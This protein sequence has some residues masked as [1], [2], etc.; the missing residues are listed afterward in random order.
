MKRLMFRWP[1]MAEAGEGGGGGETSAATATAAQDAKPAEEPAAEAALTA[2][3]DEKPAEST[4]VESGALTGKTDDNPAEKAAEVDYAKMTDDEYLGKVTLPEGQKWDKA[5]MGKYAPL[6]RESKIPPEV[7]A[8]FVALDAQI[9]KENGEAAQKKADEENKAA[10]E[11][12][13]AAG[14]AFRKEYTP[15]QMKDMNDTLS[16]IDDETFVTLITKSPLANNKTMGKMLLAYRHVYGN[17]DGVPGGDANG[18]A[19]RGFAEV[20]TGKKG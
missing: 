1:L 13:K 17:E 20:W 6:L 14:E 11:A 7:F 16:K 9:A 19:A 10:R 18:G 3:A 4:A 2:K 8:K 12:F 5:A 15:E